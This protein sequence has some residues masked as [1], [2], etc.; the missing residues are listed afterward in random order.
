MAAT[1]RHDV[2]LQFVLARLIERNGEYTCTVLKLW[3]G[4]EFV[5]T[6]TRDVYSLGEIRHGNALLALR[7]AET[8][9]Q[10]HGRCELAGLAQKHGEKQKGNSQTL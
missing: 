2:F 4:M 5:V 6:W 7:L 9:T 8:T 3:K 10:A 1:T